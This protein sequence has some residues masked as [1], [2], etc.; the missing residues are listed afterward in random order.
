[1]RI[2]TLIFALTLAA[3]GSDSEENA[4]GG[5]VPQ[6]QPVPAMGGVDIGILPAYAFTVSSTPAGD[7][8]TVW[9]PNDDGMLGI[10]VDFG[11]TLLG[12]IGLTVDDNDYLSVENYTVKA[13]TVFS[14]DSDAGDAP[15]LGS[16][17]VEVLDDLIY[18]PNVP[19]HPPNWGF[20]QVINAEEIVNLQ[21]IP[22]P[23]SSVEVSLGVGPPVWMSWGQL[24]DML[25]DELAPAWLR[26]AALATEALDFVL[27][28]AATITD[29][30]NYIDD[31]MATVNPAVI[32]CDAFTGTPPLF[33]LDQG[34]SALTWLGPGNEPMAGDNFEWSFTDCWFDDP[35][36][37][38]DKLFSGS[39]GLNDF[40]W[41]VD[42]GYQLIGAGFH[43]V[44][45]DNLAIAGTVEQPVNVF[46]ISPED[47]VTVSGGYDLVF[48]A[49][50]D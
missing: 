38:F 47:V 34:E 12:E 19:H 32:A 25:D 23:F 30:F 37:G 21:V 50:E 6:P 22:G 9:V 43:D 8:L 5:F 46:T 45:Y 42:D 13:L 15:F 16:F 27:I 40:V 49:L 7:P 36:S 24:A 35:G 44:H 28:Q 10:S 14:I 31:A 11:N 33:V 17:D 41:T 4:A 2:L 39:I 1:M 3:C 48:A 20:Y 29:T 18:M 26:R